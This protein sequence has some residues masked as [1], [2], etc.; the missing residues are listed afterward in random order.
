MRV[1]AI[2]TVFGLFL[3]F[4]STASAQLQDEPYGFSGGGP[5]LSTAGKQAILTEELTG[6]TPDNLLRRNG[7]L[8]DVTEGPDGVAIVR[9]QRGAFVPTGSVFD[10]TAIAGGRRG[11]SDGLDIV[12]STTGFAVEITNGGRTGATV[13]GW[14]A[15]VSHGLTPAPRPPV[16]GD[17]IDQWTRQAH[18]LPPA[19]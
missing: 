17:T 19:R 5:G 11:T 12:E 3:A 6:A 10:R 7:V 15:S 14:T 9:T 4:A 16:R 2:T 18:T 1:A 13:S 8:L